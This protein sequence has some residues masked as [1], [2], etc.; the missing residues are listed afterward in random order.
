MAAPEALR[1]AAS[2]ELYARAVKVLPGGVNSPVRAMRSIGRDPLFVASASGA[3]ITDVDGNTYVD[4]VCS[5]GPLVHGH[6]HPRILSAVADAAAHGT[7]FGAPTEGEVRAR[8]G[9]RAAHP[10]RRDAA[11]DVVG[12]RGVDERDPARPRGDRPRAAP[13]VR[14]RLPRARRRAPRGGRIGHRDRRDPRVARRAGGRDGRH[15]HRPVERPRRGPRRH[16]GEGVRGDPR[17]ALSGE[18]GPRP[19]A[20]RLPGAPARARR[21]QR[22]AARLR[23]GHLR[24]P[25]R[26]AAAPRASPASCPTSRSWARSSAAGCPPPRTAGRARSW[27]ASPRRATS[28]RRAR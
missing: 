25:R 7:T 16:G 6:A 14:R 17:R 24:L 19:A 4:Y 11:H 21:R 23:R 27:S 22:R 9:G 28:T 12:H 1:D 3:E 15:G 10:V 13:E 5:W 2:A 18:H 20:A 26:A 8:R